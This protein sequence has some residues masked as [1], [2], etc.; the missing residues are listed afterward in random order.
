LLRDTSLAGHAQFIVAT[1]SPILLSV[2]GASIFS[3]DEIPIARV[4]YKATS[5]YKI[6]KAFMEAPEKLLNQK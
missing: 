1:H 5:H 4:D 6:Y 3:F 2:P